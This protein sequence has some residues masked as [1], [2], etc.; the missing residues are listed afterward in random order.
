MG[1]KMTEMAENTQHNANIIGP[2]YI[3]YIY[4]VALIDIESGSEIKYRK[5]SECDGCMLELAISLTL[6][7][8]LLFLLYLYQ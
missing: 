2:F 6:F 3:L 8:G 4:Y 1:K 5:I 7:I